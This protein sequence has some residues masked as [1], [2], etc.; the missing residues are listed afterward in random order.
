MRGIVV[1]NSPGL[2]D[3]DY[4]D[5]YAVLL[6]NENSIPFIV[7]KYDRIAQMVITD[8]TIIDK[9]IIV[10]KLEETD[11]KGG[12]GHTGIG[13]SKATED[14]C[15]ENPNVDINPIIIS[16]LERNSLNKIYNFGNFDSVEESKEAFKKQ[17]EFGVAT[18]GDKG[19]HDN[20]QL[21]DFENLIK[22]IPTTSLDLT[23][24]ENIQIVDNETT[25][26]EIIVYARRHYA[27]DE[28]IKNKDLVRV[29]KNGFFSDQF[30]IMRAEEAI[31][32][33]GMNTIRLLEDYEDSNEDWTSGN[34]L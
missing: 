13:L 12:F 9:I 25:D 34:Y 10:D 30:D 32:K 20:K 1:A 19:E 28:L 22:N 8:Y 33:Y 3:S 16:E 18:I 7:S 23:P 17:C 26:E 14:I 24:I 4:R 31:I 11:R 6:K 21:S 2:C 5:E 27:G 29:W 15:I